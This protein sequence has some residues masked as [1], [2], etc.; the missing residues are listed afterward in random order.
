MPKSVLITCAGP[1]CDKTK[2]ISP[3]SVREVNFC[4]KSC[5]AAHLR[6]RYA[7]ENHPQYK[8]AN[9]TFKCE[10][11]GCTNIRTDNPSQF[12]GEHKFC[13]RRCS[14]MWTAKQGELSPRWKGGVK[15]EKRRRMT[16]PMNRL[17]SSM[18]SKLRMA[19]KQNKG[20]RHWETLVGYT[21]HDLKTHIES[22]FTEGMTWKNWGNW[23]PGGPLRWHIDHIRPQDSFT[24]TTENDAQFQE[25]WC[26][27]N[28]QPL[29]GPDNLSKWANEGDYARKVV[30]SEYIV[31]L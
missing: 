16:D 12:L 5:Y 20:G 28:L 9:I 25:C 18:G 30:F 29:W 26:L 15:E 27:A 10:R 24:F 7:G 13:S 6:I 11:K 21:V 31:S 1:G 22:L 2:F 23:K 4:A 3:S 19:L 14:N 8:G 17:N